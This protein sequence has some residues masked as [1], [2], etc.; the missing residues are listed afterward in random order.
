[1]RC[2]RL[3][4]NMRRRE[5]QPSRDAAPGAD[6][7]KKSLPGRPMTL[8]GAVAAGVRIIVWFRECSRQVE[9]DPADLARRYGDAT[10]VI[11]WRERLVCSGCGSRAVD[12]VLTGARSD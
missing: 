6:R 9:P 7:R 11:D 4:S 1:N 5:R 12:M 10:S 3:P 8:G 2:R